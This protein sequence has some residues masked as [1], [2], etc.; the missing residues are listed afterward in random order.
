MR[1]ENI[2]VRLRQ[3]GSALHH[4][5]AVK[6]EIHGEHLAFIDAKGRLSELFLMETVESLPSK[7]VEGIP[8]A[9]SFIEMA[10]LQ[11]PLAIRQGFLFAYATKPGLAT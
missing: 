6:A 7:P 10:L 3:P 9:I 1:N 11:K 4:V 8:A 2:L 5:R